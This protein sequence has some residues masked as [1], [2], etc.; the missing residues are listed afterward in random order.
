MLSEGA[1]SEGHAR[2][3]L[4]LPDEETML[5]VA[6]QVNGRDLTV[7]QT[8]ELVRRLAAGEST[9]GKADARTQEEDPQAQQTRHL[10]EVFRTA[11]GT[12]VS[13]S[14]GRRGGK[15]VIHFY[16]DEELQS[17]Y[18]QIVGETL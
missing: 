8:E 13:L 7:R 15:L 17:I 10:E 11:L 9:E 18:D 5:Q 1:L 2:A 14:R 6:E 3:L 12:K 16:S 4:G